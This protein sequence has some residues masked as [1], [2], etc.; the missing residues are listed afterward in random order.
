MDRVKGNNNLSASGLRGGL[1]ECYATN[2]IKLK[3][4]VEYT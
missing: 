4:I 1:E 2:G 3:I